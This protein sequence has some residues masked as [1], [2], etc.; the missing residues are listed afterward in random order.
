[1]QE[2]R[3]APPLDSDGISNPAAFRNPGVMST[4]LSN[5]RGIFLYVLKIAGLPG[6]EHSLKQ[7]LR[8]YELVKHSKWVEQLRGIVRRKEGFLIRYP[9]GDLRQ[10][11]RADDQKNRRWVI[12]IATALEEFQTSGYIQQDLKCANILGDDSGDI[13]MIDLENAGGTRD[14][15]H[16]DNLIGIIQRKLPQRKEESPEKKWYIVYVFGKTV[17]SCMSV[18]L[19]DTP[20]W[21]QKLVE[22]CLNQGFESIEDLVEY[23]KPY[24]EC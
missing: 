16:P 22:G 4:R 6:D 11:F 20:G 18:S 9:Q 15:A 24:E 3:L 17:W 13:R 7:E 14:W 23:L 12:Q 21:V 19:K 2:A 10:H 1:V 5:T 8:H